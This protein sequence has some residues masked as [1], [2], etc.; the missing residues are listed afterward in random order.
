[1]QDQG[2]PQGSRIEPGHGGTNPA[3]IWTTG[4]WLMCHM[5][6][7]SHTKGSFFLLSA[8]ISDLMVTGS[9]LK[10]FNNSPQEDV[11]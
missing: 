11:W 10:F 4:S 9:G 1:M 5:A 6:V 8:L 3:A 2:G 7:I